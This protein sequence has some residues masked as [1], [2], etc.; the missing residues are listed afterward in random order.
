VNGTSGA[1]GIDFRMIWQLVLRRRWVILA[2][3]VVVFGA[4]ALYTLR[5]P[6]IYGAVTSLV[7]DS[8]APRVLDN[9][10]QDLSEPSTAGYWFSK[11]YTETQI[12]IITSRAVA[13]RTVEK[14]GLQSDPEFLGVDRVPD[15]QVRSS[16][17]KRLDA[18]SLLRSKLSVST[19]KETRIVNVRIED[20]DPKRAAL[21]ANEVAEAYIAE[22]LALRLRISESANRWLEE[23][24][25]ELE[26]KTKQSE[27]AVYD[28]K[29]DADMLTT[30]L[31]DRASI[32]SQRLNTY[33]GALT[34]VRTRIAGFKAR[35]EALESLKSGAEVEAGARPADLLASGV[36]QGPLSTL[37]TRYLQERADC[38]ALSERYLLGHPKL[39]TCTQRVA[40]AR[41]DLEGEAE[42][43]IRA[44]RLE[45]TEALARE[46]NLE[47]LLA[48]AKNE[49]FDVNKRQ[50]EFERLKRDSDNNQR[51]YELVLKRL[52]D[53]ELS[54]MLRTS[55]ARVLDAARPSFA[56]V[57][58]NIRNNL[59]LGLLLGL[60]AG[61]GCAFL[62]EQLDNTVK[63]QAD[64][65]ERVGVPFL[66]LIPRIE[67]EKLS[68]SERDLYIFRN[69][70]STVAEACRAIRANLL[71]MSPDRPLRTMLITSSGPR[72]GKSA[73]AVAAGIVMAQSGS[74]VLLVDTDMRRPRLHRAFG[75]PN[76][77]GVS[78]VLVGD[79]LL[80]EVLKTTEIPGLFVIPS[81]PIPPN[82]AEMFHT[83][84]FRDFVG[85]VSSRYDRVVFDSPPVNAVADP[86]VLS[87]HVDGTL[88]VI[89]ASVTHKALAR[90]VIRVLG[91]VKARVFGAV[92]NDVELRSPKYG[93]FYAAYASE[94]YES[95]EGA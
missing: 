14:L 43:V 47:K 41:A 32:I 54:S 65:E 30:S 20:T 91:D 42:A 88:L 24:L 31:E 12:N 2:V 72:E 16:L 21:L 71:F 22:N 70:K 1:S 28:F 45:L 86:V 63:S 67:G 5:Q 76:D 69:P 80:D 40:E 9:Q 4:V 18:P 83:Q 84:A 13:E 51:L 85:T 90:R 50:I 59:F 11:E 34:D 26:Q 48:A 73:T 3:T 60:V 17:M 52:K 94:Y 7:I 55:N 61:V 89:R 38:A 6:K 58:P 68:P 39:A 25:G 87:T 19:V 77:R 92:L 37:K 79:A 74:R 35:V 15:P 53:T 82:P 75:V 49:A 29:K 64:V 27:I 62:L 81:G 95:R 56:P 78:S 8:A 10:V 44:A 33:N 57:R 23:R 66:G 46:R 36:Q 93:D